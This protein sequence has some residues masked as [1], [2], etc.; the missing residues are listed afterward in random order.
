MMQPEFLQW[1]GPI[2]TLISIGT[3]IWVW[4]TSPAKAAA[5]AASA[6]NTRVDTLE[7]RL[8][9]VETELEHLPD[10]ETF[11]QLAL[12]VSDMR[13]DI[14]AL[15]ER[16]TAVAAVSVRLEQWLDEKRL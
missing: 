8:I 15:T 2:G 4:V 11:H 9:K 7:S 5:A 14:K 10:T 6:V 1:V 3:A 12:A 13:G 16:L